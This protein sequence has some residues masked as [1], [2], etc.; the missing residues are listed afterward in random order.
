M[1][2]KTTMAKSEVEVNQDG[3][4]RGLSNLAVQMIAFGGSIGTGLFLGAGS[5]IHRTGPAILFVYLMIGIFFFLMMRAIGEMMYADPQQHTFVSF[6]GKYVSPQLGYFAAW[7]YWLELVLAGMAELTALSTYVKY[8]FPGTSS[9]MVQIVFLL[10]LT[11]VN[12]AMVSSFGKSEILLSGIKILTIL[13]LIIIGFFLVTTNHHNPAGTQASWGNVFAHFELFP[14]GFHQFI[15]AFPM[16]FFAFQ[17]MEFVG[18]TTAETKNPRKVLPH[19]VNQII[20]RILLF[21]IG[22]LLVI[23]AIT[24]WKTLNPNESPFVQIFK[25]A[26]LPAAAQVINL[27]VIVAACSTLNSAIFSTGRHL[28]QLAEESSSKSMS[29]FTQVSKNGIPVASV[30]FSALIMVLAPIISAFNS[31]GTAFSFISSVS[32][33]IYILVCI[34]TMSA[35][36]RYRHSVDFKVDG[37]KMPQYRWANP[38]TVIFFFAIFVSLLFNQASIFPALGALAWAL[39]FNLLLLYRQKKLK[40]VDVQGS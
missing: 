13:V 35:H 12:L 20:S 14:H 16:V 25:L 5:T 18:I 29:F 11:A 38:L 26:G 1:G 15:N 30:L 9:W 22:S 4:V 7:S 27:V 31:L 33:D 36:Y 23:M 28:Y 24:P 40:R 32:S 21:Y 37:F 8:W 34:L 19:A 3:T 17:G 10:I 39:G 2:M 6:I